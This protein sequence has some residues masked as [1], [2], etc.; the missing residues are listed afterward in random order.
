MAF[1]GGE[2]APLQAG[3]LEGSRVMQDNKG[4]SIPTQGF[5]ILK[6]DQCDTFSS[7]QVNFQSSNLWFSTMHN[8]DAVTALS[9]SCKPVSVTWLVGSLGVVHWFHAYLACFIIIMS[10]RGF[11]VNNPSWALGIITVRH[12]IYSDPITQTP[13]IYH[14]KDSADHDSHKWDHFFSFIF[15]FRM[16]S[17]LI[18]FDF[19]C[20]FPLHMIEE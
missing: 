10:D 12:L 6:Q 11:H 2:K 9:Y 7:V 20:L 19:Q 16:F 3:I 4:I 5:N 8:L 17:A 1:V 15:G 18:L 13:S 14:R